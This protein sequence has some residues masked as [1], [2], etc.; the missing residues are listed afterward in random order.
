MANKLGQWQDRGVPWEKFDDRGR[1]VIERSKELARPS[2]LLT[3]AHLLVAITEVEGPI[4]LAV[5]ELVGD[6]QALRSFVDLGQPR[7]NGRGVGV[8][9]L[10]RQ[11]LASAM[12]WAAKLGDQG[13][14]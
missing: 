7:G 1:V 4:R 13:G 12:S 2:G 10:A 5:G 6:A 14:P 3:T 9:L 8:A 11:A